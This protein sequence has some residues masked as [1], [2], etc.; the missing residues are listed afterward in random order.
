MAINA[1]RPVL[2]TREGGRYELMARE[3]GEDLRK[4]TEDK[5]FKSLYQSKFSTGGKI[6]E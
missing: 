5:D 4:S 2:V 6:G 1:G 3:V